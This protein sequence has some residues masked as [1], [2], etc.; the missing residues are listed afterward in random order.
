MKLLDQG[1]EVLIIKNIDVAFQDLAERI[2]YQGDLVETRAVWPDG[3]PARAYQVFGEIITYDVGHEFPIGTLRPVNFKASI[4]ELLWIWSRK[5]N[6]IAEL[7]SKIW[8]EWEQPDGTIGKAYGYQLAQKHRYII[9][10]EERWMD[11]VE[12]ILWDLDNDP[13]SRRIIASMYNFQDLHEMALYPCAYS[14]TLG[15]TRGKYLNMILNQRSQDVL[16]AMYW[17]VAQYA[18]LLKMFA[19]YGEFKVGKL[20]H[21]I[22]NAHIYDRHVEQVKILL[23]RD[24]R[25]G[26]KVCL[27]GDPKTFFTSDMSTDNIRLSNYNPHESVGKIEVAI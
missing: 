3:V 20:T 4:D 25:P 24:P 10:G 17:N 19:Y 22:A 23:G 6:K 27:H 26:A 18:A 1:M 14:I 21:V 8:D 7:N 9:D 15:V 12:K 11:Q 5:S 13:L 2:L 16:T